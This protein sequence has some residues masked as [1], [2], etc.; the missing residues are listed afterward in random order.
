MGYK[1]IMLISVIFIPLLLIVIG[2][3]FAK[4]PSKEPNI[5][6]GFRTKLSMKNKDTWD[7]AQK[8][9]PLCWIKLGTILLVISVI[10]LFLLYNDDKDYIGKLVLIIMLIQVALML[11]SIFFVNTKLK[12]A[13][14][15][16]GTR[17]QIQ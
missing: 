6:I 4:F 16:D 8:L 3:I 12:K 17:K 14:N 11:G 7:Y 13:F 10:I 9:F 2:K 15:S 1:I 5:A